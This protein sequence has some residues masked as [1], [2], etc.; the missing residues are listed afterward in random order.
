MKRDALQFG[1][2][3][4]LGLAILSL[5]PFTA[6]PLPKS[7]HGQAVG[8][9]VGGVGGGG[10]ETPFGGQRFFT[11]FCTCAQDDLDI[12]EDYRTN[13]ILLLLYEPGQSQLYEYY[14]ILFATYLLGT[15]QETKQQCRIRIYKTCINIPA[16]GVFGNKPGTG[17]SP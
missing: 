7:A 14:D 6:V 11:I 16:D 13:T 10:S 3:V 4:L 12:I 15:Y 1:A 8:G 9:G 2:R 17:T 5:I